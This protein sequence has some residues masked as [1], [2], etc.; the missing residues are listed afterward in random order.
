MISNFE[1]LKPLSNE[2]LK[3]FNKMQKIYVLDEKSIV[4][5]KEIENTFKELH[6]IFKE[7]EDEYTLNVVH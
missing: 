1:Y 7:I 5:L 6:C 3:S 4:T 2:L